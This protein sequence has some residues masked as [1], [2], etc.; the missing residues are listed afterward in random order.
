[1]LGLLIKHK[2]SIV[3]PKTYNWAGLSGKKYEYKIFGMDTNWSDVA[4]NYIFAKAINPDTWEA[5]YIGQSES[6][7]SRLPTH[8]EL[9][10]I[11]RNGVTHIH[12]HVNKAEQDRINEEADLCANYDTP[13]NK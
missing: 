7:R 12:A 5:I 8:N 6:L 11:K 4:G 1:L 10:C 13:C 9:P 2:G 3:V